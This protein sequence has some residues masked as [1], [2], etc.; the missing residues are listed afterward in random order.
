VAV[1]VE[2]LRNYVGAPMADDAFLTE[3]LATSNELISSYIGDATV[4][5]PVLDNCT[6]QVGSEMFY[7][8]SAPSGITQFAS[9][10]GTTQRVAKDPL[11]S[12]YTMLLRYTTAGV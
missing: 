10:D 7:R 2:D 4:P 3:C 9:L 1:T 12:V 11:T 5:E 6:L 8:R